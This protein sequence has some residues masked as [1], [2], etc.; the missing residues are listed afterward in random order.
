[1]NPPE[2]I[3]VSIWK[4]AIQDY[5][6]DTGFA[7][8]YKFD[9]VDSK[10]AEAILD[11]IENDFIQ[12]RQK[13]QKLRDVIKP[14]LFAAGVLS[15]VVAEGAAKVCSQHEISVMLICISC[16]VQK[17]PP[18][19]VISASIRLLVQ[20]STGRSRCITSVGERLLVGSQ[21]C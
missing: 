1:M 21:G 7:L 12:N 14:V 15:E 9:P 11:K 17:F 13:W 3:W 2:D 16:C 19:K 4:P 5:Q 10:D 20:V 8:K 18:A 6:R